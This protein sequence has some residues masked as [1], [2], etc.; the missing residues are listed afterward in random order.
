MRD[1]VSVFRQA[2]GSFPLIA[3]VVL[4][5]VGGTFCGIVL[6]VL[7]GEGAYRS[8]RET[9]AVIAEKH[10]RSATTTSST[11]YG[12]TYTARPPEGGEWRNTESVDAAT[13][14][15][16]EAGDTIRVQYAPGNRTSLRIVRHSLN[17]LLAAIAV[18]TGLLALLGLSLV[19][20]GG[21]DVTRKIRLHR[22]GQRAEGTV[23]AVHETGLSI[24]RRIQWV[25][26]FTFCDHL[27]QTQQGTSAPMPPGAALEWQEGDK[28]TVRFDLERPADSVW[29]G[30][31]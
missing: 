28:G 25:I 7:V 10:L 29:V 9:D 24:N 16:V 21:R 15:S 6:T 22:R 3:G 27:G 18:L 2:V 17:G 20:R 23:T 12:L 1:G 26:D 30:N 5:G 13:W 19:V 8:G 14:D 31:R 11:S 4:L